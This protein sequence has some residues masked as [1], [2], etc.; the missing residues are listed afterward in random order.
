MSFLSDIGRAA[1]F[2]GAAGGGTAIALAILR[3]KSDSD[4][5]PTGKVNDIINVVKDGINTLAGQGPKEEAATERQEGRERFLFLDRLRDPFG[6]RAQARRI[7][8]ELQ[9]REKARKRTVVGGTGFA[10]SLFD[11]F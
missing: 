1:L 9:R 8:L 5:G 7:N 3:Q 10:G 6:N 2:L 4:D 11:L